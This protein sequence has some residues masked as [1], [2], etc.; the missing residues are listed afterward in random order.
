MRI[1]PVSASVFA[2]ALV[3]FGLLVVVPRAMA[4]DTAKAPDPYASLKIGNGAHKSLKA[5]ADEEL[6]ASSSESRKSDS[7]LR[8]AEK[9]SS[10]K[11]ASKKKS[12]ASKNA[13]DDVSSP[14][15]ATAKAELVPEKNEQSVG[16]LPTPG[17]V[18]SSIDSVSNPV[19]RA[20]FEVSIAYQTYKPAGIMRL[21]S[22]D[23]FDLGTIPAGPMI[24]AEVRWFA[25]RFETARPLAVGPFLS[26]DYSQMPVKLHSPS[27]AAISKTELHILK[28]EVGGS[29]GWQPS[30]GS[31]WGA[32]LELGGGQLSETQASTSSFA[33]HTSSLLFASAGIYGERKVLEHLTVFVGYDYSVPVA[34]EPDEISLQRSNLLAGL[35]GGFQ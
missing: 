9:L 17:T 29:L 14:I 30:V 12:K 6:S 22:M 13:A 3:F 24:D 2:F 27:G 33:N 31:V 32:R 21:P 35:S 20:P 26:V 10:R 23:A 4:D 7:H 11:A 28:A 16:I 18:R 1:T 15:D 25:K 19:T 8:L 5:S 34:H